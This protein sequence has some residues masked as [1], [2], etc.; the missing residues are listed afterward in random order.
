MSGSVEKTSVS[1][2]FKEFPLM[3]T[4]ERIVNFGMET[5]TFVQNCQTS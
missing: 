3:Y 1:S 5:L 2:L 4:S